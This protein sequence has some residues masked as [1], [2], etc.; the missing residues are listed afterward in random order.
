[1][2]GK[3]TCILTSDELRGG[4]ARAAAPQPPAPAAARWTLKEAY[5][6][7]LGTGLDR[8]GSPR[9]EGSQLYVHPD[10]CID[11]GLCVDACPNQAIFSDA[12][13][14][15]KWRSSVAANFEHFGLDA[16]Y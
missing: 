1:L 12:E 15:D 6:K 3:G 5:L 7:A 14:P 11:C 4:S 16:P 9:E 13:L 8:L 10:E 2:G